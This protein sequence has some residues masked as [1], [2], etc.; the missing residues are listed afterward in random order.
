MLGIES[1]R[2]RVG[3]RWEDRTQ[4]IHTVHHRHSHYIYFLV[5]GHILLSLSR[6]M[7]K[8]GQS[9]F[10]FSPSKCS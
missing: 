4:F 10:S 2:T 5:S 9:V 3:K 8:V 7:V 6:Q 1:F